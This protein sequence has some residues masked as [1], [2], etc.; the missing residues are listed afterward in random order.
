MCNWCVFALVWFLT[1]ESTSGV[2]HFGSGMLIYLMFSLCKNK[3]LTPLTLTLLELCALIVGIWVV[4]SGAEKYAVLAFSALILV[5]AL[6]SYTRAMTSGGGWITSVLE[7]RF[8][9]FFGTLSYSIY[10]SHYFVISIMKAAMSLF[11]KYGYWEMVRIH[12]KLYID[13]H[14]PIFANLYLALN[15]CIVVLVAYVLHKY[16]EQPCIAFGKKLV[17]KHT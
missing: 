4:Y 15:L 17:K 11:A 9:I 13:F 8:F 1:N 14:N 6:S 16:I 12:E 10:I 2:L 3:N 5:F 7:S